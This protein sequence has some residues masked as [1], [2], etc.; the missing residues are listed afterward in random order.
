[1][2]IPL[3]RFKGKVRGFFS[4]SFPYYPL[5]ET[6]DSSP[7]FGSYESQRYGN[8]DTS[9]C[10]DFSAT[11][12]L[13]TRLHILRD[14]N[15]IPADTMKW[16]Q[17]NGYI[18]SDGDFYL[19]RRWVAILSGVKSAGNNQINFW[20]IVGNGTNAGMIPNSMLPYNPQDAFKYTTQDDFNNDYFN[21]QV[22]T[23]EMELMGKEFAKRFS[24]MAENMWGGQ[25]DKVNAIFQTYL[26][27]G[28]MQIG[29]PVPQ[30]GSWNRQL[31]D[32]PVGNINAQHA[33]EI[34]KFDP[35]Q[36]YPFYDYDSY[37]PNLKQ[38]SANYYLPIITRVVIKPLPVTQSVPV[39]KVQTWMQFWCNVAAWI[40][41][42]PLPYPSITIGNVV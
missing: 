10:W 41:G 4:Q 21:P 39:N 28:S 26:K 25:F 16:L 15:L 14:L 11:E 12:V 1:M 24:I 20:N 30:D 33:T 2:N 29:H 37:M 3:V 19:S 9:C 17:D 38:L 23:K 42:N 34:Y 35:T 22:I 27:E 32:Y 5:L 31:V 18:D 8:W 40:Q 36:K 6:G 13:E 7:Y